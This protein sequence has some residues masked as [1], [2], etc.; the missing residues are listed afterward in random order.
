MNHLVVHLKPRHYCKSTI[1]QLK[2]GFCLSFC[3]QKVQAK[4]CWEIILHD[5]H[6]SVHLVNSLIAF[7][8]DYL[9]KD[10]SITNDFG[11]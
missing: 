5:S 9:F 11:S 6:V 3:L 7:V 2:K 10:V 4:T 1:F 8:P